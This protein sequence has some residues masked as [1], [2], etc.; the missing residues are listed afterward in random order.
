M[1]SGYFSSSNCVKR[2]LDF[3]PKS[4]TQTKGLKISKC[5]L[6]LEHV[7]ELNDVAKALVLN[8]FLN[9]TETCRVLAVPEVE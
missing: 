3:R 1:I 7:G 2:C 4:R 8:S 5:S 9:S 6:H